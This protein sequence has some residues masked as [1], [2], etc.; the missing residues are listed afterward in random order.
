MYKIKIHMQRYI[1][2]LTII[3]FIAWL[4]TASFVDPETSA[5]FPKCMFLHITGFE[6]P[7]CGSQRAAYQLMHLNVSAAWH[8]NP[9]LIIAIPF[10][11]LLFYMQYLGGK[12]RFPKLN[13][14]LSGT[15]AVYIITVIIIIYWIG[16][17]II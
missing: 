11:V 15:T 10:V 12:K 14:A 7:G 3:I 8:Y 2:A 4:L 9:L 5:L 13:E 6:C 16:R 1:I 17:N